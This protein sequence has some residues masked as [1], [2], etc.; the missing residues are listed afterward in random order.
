MRILVTGSRDLTD[1]DL[2]HDALSELFLEGDIDE[3]TVVHGGARGADRIAGQWAG[4]MKRYGVKEEVF[5]A[6]WKQYGRRAGHLRNAEMI[7]TRP[8]RV[9]AFYH[10]EARNLGTRDCVKKARVAGIPVDEYTQTS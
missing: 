8:D 10:A 9:L 1:Y 7:A 2:V 3:F 4:I 5:N 6:D